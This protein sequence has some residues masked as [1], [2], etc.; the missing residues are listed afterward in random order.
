MTIAQL[1]EGDELVPEPLNKA[2]HEQVTAAVRAAAG[3]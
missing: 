1:A 2:V 3:N